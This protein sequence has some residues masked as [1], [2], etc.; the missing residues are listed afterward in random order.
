MKDISDHYV[1]CPS[2]Y[3]ECEDTDPDPCVALDA[4]SE[5]SNTVG[6][7]YCECPDGYTWD[8]DQCTGTASLPGEFSL[9]KANYFAR[10]TF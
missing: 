1:M 4:M 6:S 5:C 2:D 9:N 3:D 8:M 10:N 7:F